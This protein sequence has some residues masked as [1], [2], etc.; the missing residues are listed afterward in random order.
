MPTGIWLIYLW[1]Y[2]SFPISWSLDIYHILRAVLAP[3]PSF[4]LIIAL[5]PVTCVLPSF[6][7]Q[8]LARSAADTL[9][10]ICSPVSWTA[11]LGLPVKTQMRAFVS[12]IS[13]S[14]GL[15]AHQAR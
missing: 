12:Q 13:V 3:L 2:G 8:Q 7:L 4:W 6:M 10:L 15:Q 14:C 11:L 5:V 1:I 9:S